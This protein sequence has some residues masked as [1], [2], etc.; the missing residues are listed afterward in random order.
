MGIGQAL[1]RRVME[2]TGD[3]NTCLYSSAKMITS[4]KEKCGFKVIPA[5]KMVAYSGFPQIFTLNKY[6]TDCDIEYI[7]GHNIGEVIEYDEEVCGINRNRFIELSVAEPGSVALLAR[8]ITNGHIA[9]YAIF[10]TTNFNS[11]MP[12]PLYADN[13][14]IA[15]ALTYNCIDKFV[16]YDGL[17]W[18]TWDVNEEANW[19]VTKLG[20]EKKYMSPVMFTRQDVPANNF[21]R[22]FAISPSDFYPY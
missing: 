8:Y 14:Y 13:D 4:Y 19:L 3:R 18:Q 15:E 17:Y 2:H 11:I 5:R 16:A 1:W 10:K 9:G 6:L 20:L 12:R 22:I 7:S 21:K